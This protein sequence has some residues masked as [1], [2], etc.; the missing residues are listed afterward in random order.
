M[1]NISTYFVPQSKKVYSLMKEL[2]N[3]RHKEET[4]VKTAEAE[5]ERIKHQANSAIMRRNH[6]VAEEQRSTHL[7]RN[8]P[9]KEIRLFK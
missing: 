5:A 4:A 8:N 2:D 7:Q 6:A 9:V 3:E 1:K